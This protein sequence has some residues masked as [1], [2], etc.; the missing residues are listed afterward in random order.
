MDTALRLH[1]LGD[2]I[3]VSLSLA[4]GANLA[5]SGVVAAA[6]SLTPGLWT[7]QAKSLVGVAHVA[8]IEVWIKPKVDIARIVFML[9]YARDPKGWRDQDVG[10][11]PQQEL[12]PALAHTFERQADRALQQ[13]L[14]QGYKRIEDSLPVL[15]G[16]LREAEQL[17]RRFGLPMPLE[18]AFDDFTIDIPE[19]QLLLGAARRLLR[20][21]RVPV[22]VRRRLVRL[23]SKMF[24]VTEL[25][26]GHGLPQWTPSRLNVR[27]HVALRLAEMVLHAT[28]AEQVSGPVRV[29]GFLFDMAVIFEDFVTVAMS[30]SLARYGGRAA[31]QD[32]Q[33]L[34][35][36]AKIRMKPDLVWYSGPRA[37]AV[38]DAKYKAEKPSGFPGADLYQMLAYCTALGLER[39]D[40][41]YAK[42]N[43]VAATHTVRNA[44]VEIVQHALDLSQP[45]KLLLDQVA[46]ITRKVVEGSASEPPHPRF[47][48]PSEQ[49]SARWVP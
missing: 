13:G 27:Y 8:G 2:P 43:E 6:Q 29:N 42:G 24:D 15:R 36:A 23:A 7:V 48:R 30:E 28:S 4:A 26:R 40:L 45:P 37:A 3:E 31:P 44:G 21:P 10:L 11:E 33:H 38:I 19:N 39:G 17:K 47:E 12:M 22:E 1:E 14:L 35:A 18:V 32:P 5:S 9:G 25:V 16:R 20:L 49:F 34:D 46:D 41:V